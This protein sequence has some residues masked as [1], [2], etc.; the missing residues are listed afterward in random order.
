[1]CASGIAAQVVADATGDLAWSAIWG[2]MIGFDVNNPGTLADGARTRDVYDAPAHGVTGFA[3]DIDGVPPGGHLRVGFAT[4]G[5]ENDAAYWGGAS[6]DL[7]PI[8]SSG[9]Y[10][11]RWPEVGGPLYLPNPPPF[12]PAK[13]D[14]IR[15]HVVANDL[16][17]IPFSFCVSNLML[18][19]N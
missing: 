7:S 8:M 9:H 11:I 15:F 3:F 17:T 5:T 10:E 12:D 1:M 16:Q 6:T 19:T 18:L 13:L 14:A 4:R 2:D